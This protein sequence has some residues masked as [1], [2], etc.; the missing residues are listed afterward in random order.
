M[1]TLTPSV[2]NVHPAAGAA[3]LL[4][5]NVSNPPACPALDAQ[6]SALENELRARYGR[7]T[8]AEFCALANIQPYIR[9]YAAFKK[10]YH[11]LLQLESVAIKGRNL[12][13]VAAL[14]EA[15]FMAELNNQLL[16]AG[17][18][19]DA[20]QPPV[21]VDVAAGNE[22]YTQL[23]GQTQTLKAGDLFMRDSLGILS[24]ILSGPDQRS[25]IT[26][27]TQRVLF[28]VYAP[29]GISSAALQQH[30]TDLEDHVRLISPAARRVEKH[31]LPVG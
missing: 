5:E 28:V 30:L 14:V 20:I 1:F 26:A 29:P 23:N 13:N 3:C 12:P 10:T 9:Y 11:V 6:K 2:Q 17:H 25:Q 15:M 16:T 18:D 8:R 21:T 24:S 22:S 31:I 27:G 7:Y 19:W 4:L